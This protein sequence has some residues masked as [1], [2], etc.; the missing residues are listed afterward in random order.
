MI[1]KEGFNY[2]FDASKCKAC[3]GKCCIGESGWVFVNEKEI[4]EIAKYL[5]IDIDKFIEKY[6]RRIGNR[7]SLIEKP[8]KTGRACIFFNDETKQCNIYD[9]RPNNCRT[10]PFWDIF[11][12]NPKYAQMECIGVVV[13]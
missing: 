4:Q 6:T 11:K 12:N 3:G 7:I 8:H 9:F 10:F 5:E 1:R 13:D 2:S